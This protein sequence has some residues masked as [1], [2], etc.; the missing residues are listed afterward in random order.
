MRCIVIKFQAWS[1]AT[2]IVLPV[3]VSG[4][5]P[6]ATTILTVTLLLVTSGS[7]AKPRRPFIQ[8]LTS[9]GVRHRLLE[10]GL[11]YAM[12]E[13]F[14]DDFEDPDA[15]SIHDANKRVLSDDYGHLRY[16]KRGEFDEYGHMRF[17]RSI[18]RSTGDSIHPSFK[19]KVKTYGNK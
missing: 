6:T 13:E 15:I 19:H 2:E 11:P 14:L 3:M 1:S 7:F 12:L 10:G 5:N 9:T 8:A 18:G 16:G 4:L 17:G